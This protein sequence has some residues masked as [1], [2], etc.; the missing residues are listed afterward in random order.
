MVHSGITA[1]DAEKHHAE[2]V[3]EDR[4]HGK[5]CGCRLHPDGQKSEHAAHSQTDGPAQQKLD[6]SLSGGYPRNRFSHPPAAGFW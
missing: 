6:G 4:E 3:S 1:A 5:I 2:G